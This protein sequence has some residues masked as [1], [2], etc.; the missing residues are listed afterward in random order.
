[1]TSGALWGLFGGSFD[2]VHAGHL[3]AARA[4]RE[5][6]GLE[7]VLFVPAR[8]SPHKQG[9]PPAPGPARVELLELALAD[10]PDFVIDRRELGRAGPSYT[11]DTVRELLAERPDVELALILGS[12]NL[13]GLPDWR[14]VHELLGLV[15]PI[16]VHRSE[17]PEEL[18]V[19]L[20]GRL[21]PEEL[22]ALRAGFLR[23]PTVDCS[24]TEVRER[25]AAGAA[26]G[27]ALP[28]GV[29]ARIRELGLYRE[30]D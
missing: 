15:R 23:L 4:A 6:F 14:G 9:V 17:H 25:L 1:M 12:D 18:L 27:T 7:R 26:L 2:P 16:I 24:S 8:Q 3:H 29:E 22:A 20:E 11:L 28:A 30:A 5:A 10:E 21:T 19:D 13:R